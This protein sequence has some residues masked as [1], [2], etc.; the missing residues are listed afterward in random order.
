MTTD[1]SSRRSETGWSRVTVLSAAGALLAALA[2]V[3]FALASGESEPVGVATLP[4][5][6][7]AVGLDDERLISVPVSDIPDNLNRLRNSG[8]SFTRIDVGWAQIA[9]S[10]PASPTDPSDPAYQWG[11]YDAI[12]DGLTN[13]G[14]GVVASFSQVP[15]W[16]NEN[17]TPEWFGDLDAYGDF[18]RA[19]AAR[20]SGDRHGRVDFY[21][22]WNE[23]NNS[24]TLMPQWDG[25]GSDATPM[26]PTTYA[27]IFA[28]AKDAIGRVAPKAAV[29]GLGLADIE[30]STGG[31]GGVGVTD[32]IAALEGSGVSMDVVSQHLAP[33]DIPSRAPATV[34]S[35]GG[36]E[37]Y[38]AVV[39]E[40]APGVDVLITSIGYATPPGG[41]S[42]ADQ[43]TAIDEAMTMLASH[44]R[45]R[46]AIW[47]SVQDTLARPSGL[48]REDG[49]EKPAWKAFLDVP[50]TLPSGSTP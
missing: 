50:K 45:V 15:G 2:M 32:F 20:Y 48:I 1:Q 9:P 26:S 35:V 42:E 19:F 43:A 41:L 7:M 23:P 22:P 40:V 6:Q 44:R 29:V 33:A 39:D 31:V 36:M 27:E 12:I 24:A 37:D 13:R 30:R 17:R 28:R 10:R 49:R 25:V 21:E 34:P 8:V 5:G 18:V 4:D 11:R 3:I 16:A 38:F 46:L 47:Y 14:I